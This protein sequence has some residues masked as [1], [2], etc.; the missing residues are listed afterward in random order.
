MFRFCVLLFV[1]Q[2]HEIDSVLTKLTQ[3]SMGISVKRGGKGPVQ[4]IGW[5]ILLKLESEIGSRK[6]SCWGME[7]ANPPHIVVFQMW[8]H[9][10]HTAVVAADM[11]WLPRFRGVICSLRIACD[12]LMVMLKCQFITDF[13]RLCHTC[14]LLFLCLQDCIAPV[15]T[16]SYTKH[17]GWY[18]CTDLFIIK[19]CLHHCFLYI[20]TSLLSFH[21]LFK[22]FKNYFLLFF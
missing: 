14:V 19:I 11:G 12:V 6:D 16:I 4:H 3:W 9:N 5:F 2:P 17:F 13:L 10:I 1:T 22:Y 18:A 20:P 8:K 21:P 7:L 15:L